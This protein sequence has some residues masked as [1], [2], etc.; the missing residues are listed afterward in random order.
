MM[1]TKKS[2]TRIGIGTGNPGVFQGYPYPY[3]C[4]RV[5]VL[6]GTGTGFP[7]KSH[8]RISTLKT[9][10]IITIYGPNDARRVVWA[11][12]RLRGPSL[13][14]I[15]YPMATVGLRGPVLAFVGRRWL[16]W[17][18]VGLRWPSLAAVG[19]R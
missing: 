3:P 7:P 12:F 18:F 14:V 8:K 2:W 6:R 19:L 5:R 15:S 9:I 13:A 16:L 4:S 10:K 11:L 17:V 1:G